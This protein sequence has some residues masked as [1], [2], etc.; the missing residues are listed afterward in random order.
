M[1]LVIPYQITLYL[2]KICETLGANLF[3]G[4]FTEQSKTILFED[5]DEE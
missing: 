5:N 4:T 3:A 2:S 1:A